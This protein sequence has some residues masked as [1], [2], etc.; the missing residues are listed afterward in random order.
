[1]PGAG[2]AALSEHAKAA[3]PEECGESRVHTL[4]DA[5][6]L[7]PHPQEGGSPFKEQVYLISA[8]CLSTSSVSIIQNIF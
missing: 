1:M 8:Q 3:Q 5:L 6:E 7:P 2:R 4:W